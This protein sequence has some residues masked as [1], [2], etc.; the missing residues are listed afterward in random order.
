MK[1]QKRRLGVFIEFDHSEYDYLFV[2]EIR[3]IPLQF[4]TVH[5]LLSPSGDVDHSF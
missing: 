4:Q 3:G 2:F 1:N 5:P